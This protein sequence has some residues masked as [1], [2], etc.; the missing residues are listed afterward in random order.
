M[1]NSSHVEYFFREHS[2]LRTDRLPISFCLGGP[3][4]IICKNGEDD[5]AE[6][7]SCVIDHGSGQN[8]KGQIS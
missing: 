1:R 6:W 2:I 7:S 3:D 8:P 4:A 5:E